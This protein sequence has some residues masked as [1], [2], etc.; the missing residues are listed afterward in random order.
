[1]NLL[2]DIIPIAETLRG[3]GI[4]SPYLLPS[5]E[6]KRQQAYCNTRLAV[7]EALLRRETWTPA[8]VEERQLELA[9]AAQK[10]WPADLA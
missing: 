10:L 2:R 5:F 8:A 9:Q 4:M 1:L 3:I 7:T 6:I